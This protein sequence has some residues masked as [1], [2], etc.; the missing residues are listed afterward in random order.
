MPVY[1]AHALYGID[2][3]PGWPPWCMYRVPGGHG[4]R[5]SGCQGVRV[6]LGQGARVPGSHLPGCQALI[7]Q[8]CQALICQGA[9]GQGAIGQ[10]ARVSVYPWPG[11]QD[12]RVPMARVPV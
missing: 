7:C 9:I 4:A 8:R 5:V 3:A 2:K 6:P 11:C 12:V 10:G 1:P